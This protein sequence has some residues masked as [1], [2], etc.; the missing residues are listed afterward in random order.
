MLLTP[1]YCYLATGGCTA[2]FSDRS[3][4]S[5]IATDTMA[6]I[7]RGCKCYDRV[8]DTTSAA[9]GGVNV[10]LFVWLI[11]RLDVGNRTSW[12]PREIGWMR[13]RGT[14]IMPTRTWRRI[15]W[16]SW[17]Q[18]T[19]RGM[20]WR[21]PCPPFTRNSSWAN[22][23]TTSVGFRL[24]IFLSHFGFI[25]FRLVVFISGRALQRWAIGYALDRLGTEM[26]RPLSGRSIDWCY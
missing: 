20:P 17:C 26:L 9:D 2:S 24:V 7:I 15:G 4:W 21:A 8:V 3:D 18:A 23:L 16:L 11:V 19:P 25:C 13:C 1:P 22:T 5:T 10:C 14:G 6:I 12:P